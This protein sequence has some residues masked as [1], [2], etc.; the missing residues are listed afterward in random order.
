MGDCFAN[1][2]LQGCGK[3]YEIQVTKMCQSRLLF[4]QTLYFG[5]AWLASSVQYLKPTQ[6]LL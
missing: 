2:I 4:L 1:E 5:N 6:V 3:L